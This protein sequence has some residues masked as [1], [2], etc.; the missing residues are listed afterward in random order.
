MHVAE[1]RF[2][3]EGI[4]AELGHL[5]CFRVVFCVGSP[6]CCPA[7]WARFKRY[8]SAHVLLINGAVAYKTCPH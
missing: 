8:A 2:G 1:G 7:D 3:I 4:C 5:G 6:T